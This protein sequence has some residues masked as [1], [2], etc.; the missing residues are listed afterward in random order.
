MQVLSAFVVAATQ[1]SQSQHQQQLQDPSA[2][3]DNPVESMKKLSRPRTMKRCMAPVCESFARSRGFCKAHGGG[4]RCN[5]LGC[6]LSDQG[7]G[8]CIRHGGGKRCEVEGC[9][10]SAQSRRFCKAHGGGVRCRVEGCQ[11]TSQG[12]GCCRMHGGGPRS[13][14][15]S[16]LATTRSDGARVSM[17]ATER[18][19]ALRDASDVN[20]ASSDAVTP[21][22]S[23]GRTPA[24]ECNAPRCSPAAVKLEK[25][26][27]S[28]MPQT[29]TMKQLINEEGGDFEKKTKKLTAF[30]VESLHARAQASIKL[31]E[32]EEE[33]DY[34]AESRCR[35]GGCRNQAMSSATQLCSEHSTNLTFAVSLLGML[36]RES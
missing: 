11:K 2:K 15:K 35:V 20:M 18:L 29:G 14:K 25:A 26:E 23:V 16:G 22:S 7:G 12:G 32:R 21:L 34:D 8:F 3:L 1:S 24:R 4:K 33:K 27:G 13:Q 30:T 19:R 10:K 17:R 6:M 9:L 36:S 28:F 31:E 5:Q